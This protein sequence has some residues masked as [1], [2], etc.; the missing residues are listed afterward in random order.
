MEPKA[1]MGSIEHL[2]HN[3][4]SFLF[5]FELEAFYQTTDQHEVFVFDL[6]DAIH[7]VPSFHHG[8]DPDDCYQLLDDDFGEFDSS[9]H[10]EIYL[11]FIGSD[12]LMV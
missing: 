6:R 3:T 9:C 12:V 2:D 1:S 8:I 10:S 7:M 11:A 4:L 5:G